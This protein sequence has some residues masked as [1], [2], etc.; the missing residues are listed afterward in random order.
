MA[1]EICIGLQLMWSAWQAHSVLALL[2]MVSEQQ[3]MMFLGGRCALHLVTCVQKYLI[4][5]IHINLHAHVYT[6]AFTCTCR[7]YICMCVQLSLTCKWWIQSHSTLLGKA[8]TLH[9]CDMTLCP[10]V[11]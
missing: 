10:V 6:S 4:A 3:M 9:D 5:C 8:S 1:L 7:V 2:F 11:G